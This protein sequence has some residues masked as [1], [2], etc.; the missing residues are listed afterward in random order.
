MGGVSNDVN[1]RN[2]VT[3]DSHGVLELLGEA[4]LP[5][6]GV[7]EWLPYFVVAESGGEIIGVAGLEEYASGALLRSVVV[8]PGWKGRGVGGA[9]V[10]A[11]LNQ[12]ERS[13]HTHVYLLTTT[14]ERYFPRHGFRSISR[15]DVPE[16]VQQSVEFREACPA[17]AAVMV[18]EL[19]AARASAQRW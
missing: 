5:S 18:K 8:A 10:E 2:A 6:A 15:G 1:I 11:V 14:A 3:G 4:G 16:E 7:N 12:A 19:R 9:L 17:S 13:G